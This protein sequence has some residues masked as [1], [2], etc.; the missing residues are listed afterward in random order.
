MYNIPYFKAY[1]DKEDIKAVNAV[2][3]RGKLW[4]VGPNTKS[5]ERKISKY[6]GVKYAVSFNSG[7]SA[8]YSLV[9]A[10]GIGKG[11]EVIVPS[12]TFIATANACLFAGAKPV[13]VDIENETFGLNPESIRKKITKNTKAIIAV[14]YGG[15]P[16]KIKEIKRIARSY[17]LILIEDA[18]GILGGNING[19]KIGSFGDSAIFSFCG[20][21]L[22]T[23]GEGGC[24]VT[25]IKKVYQ[26][27]KL[28]R[29]H[30]MIKKRLY[31]DYVAFGCNLRM[32]DITA[33]LGLSQLKK[34]ERNIKLRR[35]VAGYLTEKLSMIG[36]K[37]KLPPL[38]FNSFSIYQNYSIMVDKRV[39]DTLIKYLNH[40]GIC[41]RV[42]YRPVHLSSFYRNMF[43]YKRD[44]LPVTESISAQ[45][46]NLPIYATLKKAEIDYMVRTIENFLTS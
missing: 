41:A 6:V 31:P 28:I 7:T 18:A 14:H 4:T 43:G 15:C 37:P 9:L 25:S 27:L 16:C 19:K 32:S 2:I 22:I 45:I 33:A 8:L 13:F 5:F 12:F 39:R 34:L 29:A 42:Y 38:I 21:K 35:K 20:N 36:K 24:A 1:W 44:V 3:K 17:N 11:D 40:K 10:H 26:R 46:L 30:G 23:T